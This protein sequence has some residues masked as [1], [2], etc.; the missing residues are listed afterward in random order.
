MRRLERFEWILGAAIVAVMG[1]A[2]VWQRNMESS[3]TPTA[4]AR[5]VPK[6]GQAPNEAPAFP[7]IRPSRPG[8]RAVIVM[9]HD[10]VKRRGSGSVYFDTTVRE[11]EQDIETIEKEGGTVVPLS[12]V[13][14]ALT[15]DKTLPPNAVALT[16]DDGY[17]GFYENAFP[18]LKAKGYPSTVFMHTAFIGKTEG[19]HPKMT[20]EQLREL[21]ASGLVDVESHTVTHPEDITTL[22][23]EKIRT[24]LT[25]SKKVL[26][27]ALGKEV[28]FLSWPIGKN[29]ALTQSEAKDAGYKL[30]VTMEPGLAAESPNV[31]AV[32]R[33][34]RKRLE[35]S[36]KRMAAAPPVGYAEV[37]WQ[38]A[39]VSLQDDKQGRVELLTLTGG[40]PSSVLIDGRASVAE[41]V[42]QFQGV[43]GINGGFFSMAA[44]AATDNTMIGPCM[45]SN[46]SYLVPDDDAARAEKLAGRPLVVWG[47]TKAVITPFSPKSLNTDTAIKAL[48]PDM[49]DAF[50]AGAWLVFQGKPLTKEEIMGAATSDAQDPRKRSFFGLTQDGRLIVGATKNG[51]TSSML[52]E[53]AAQ[54]GA[55]TAVLL[56][57]G[58][59]TSLFVDGKTLAWGHR[60]AEGGSRPV[61]HAIVIKG[62]L[63]PALNT[64]GMETV[65][66][67]KPETRRRRRR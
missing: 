56:D 33:I 61:P 62:G 18:I 65:E 35:E 3:G 64:E 43:A 51:A 5:V 15:G 39:P 2:V 22:T 54:A 44:I 7:D 1:G 8:D 27:E 67:A 26:E 28:K 17:L 52:A 53:A 47:P 49:T 60:G 11:L 6:D 38:D 9:Y 58:F 48:V 13:Y 34:T 66:Q 30:A 42:S 40:R 24:E 31:L 12:D 57:S 20:L 4:V 29:D 23:T 25:E 41:I 59:S 14:D 45:A 55:W 37:A 16:F 46:R 63:D 32:N 50:V 21:E 19:S 10:V 36:L